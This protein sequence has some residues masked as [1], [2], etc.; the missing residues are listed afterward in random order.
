VRQNATTFLALCDTTAEV[1]F[2]C[3]LQKKVFPFLVG[4]NE[5]KSRDIR[6]LFFR[7]IPQ[8]MSFSSIVAQNAGV[9]LPFSTVY[10][11]I[12]EMGNFC[13]LF[14]QNKPAI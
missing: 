12:F 2:R 10:N 6:Q 9:L 4:F 1:F 3:G 7:C 11:V 14:R 5:E 13:K 8:C